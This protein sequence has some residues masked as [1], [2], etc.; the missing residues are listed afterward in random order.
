M[1]DIRE[2]LVVAVATLAVVTWFGKAYGQSAALLPE[3]TRVIYP[4]EQITA[5]S[6]VDVP[7]A[8]GGASENVTDRNQIVGKVARLTLLPRHPIPMT[9][10]RE[11]ALVFSGQ[12][13]DAYYSDGQLLIVAKV[14]PL[15]DG[16]LGEQ[17]RVRNIDSTKIITATV[18]L[19]GRVRLQAP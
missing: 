11:P 5:D 14:M 19:D 9:A 2:A 10:L 1:R 17:I 8:S 3:P 4:G 18:Q 13:T 15:Q 6:L 12:T 16:H 7:T